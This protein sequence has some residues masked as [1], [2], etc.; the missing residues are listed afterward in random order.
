MTPPLAP[1]SLGLGCIHEAQIITFPVLSAL[2]PL[3]SLSPAL[4]SPPLSL[5]LQSRIEKHILRAAFDV[6]GDAKKNETPPAK[7]KKTVWPPN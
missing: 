4:C 1:F 3:P 7:K 5:L 6:E 2:H